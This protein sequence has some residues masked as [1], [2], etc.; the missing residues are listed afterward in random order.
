M[1]ETKQDFEK[2]EMNSLRKKMWATAG[3]HWETIEPNKDWIGYVLY[4]VHEEIFE[5]KQNKNNKK[6]IVLTVGGERKNWSSDT[7]NFLFE[8][9]LVAYDSQKKFRK[10]LKDMAKEKKT[11]P[12]IKKQ[13]IS[14]VMA[15]KVKN[16]VYE[17]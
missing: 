5:I 17:I 10:T 12:A 8:D 2:A 11:Q 4:D 6:D 16:K 7:L 15:Q 9:V 1:T 3:V 14:V 13:G